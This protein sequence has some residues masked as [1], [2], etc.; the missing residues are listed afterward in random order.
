MQLKTMTSRTARLLLT[1]QEKQS[2]VE[3]SIGLAFR[4]KDVDDCQAVLEYKNLKVVVDFEE[5][6][7]RIMTVGEFREL[8]CTTLVC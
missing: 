3:L 2:L 7:L 1:E 5:L 4:E 6:E 8:A